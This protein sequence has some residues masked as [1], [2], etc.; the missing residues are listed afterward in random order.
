MMEVLQTG[1]VVAGLVLLVW[2]WARRWGEGLLVAMVLSW[3]SLFSWVVFAT[4]FSWPISREY[5]AGGQ[6]LVGIK[7]LIIAHR[8]GVKIWRIEW[9]FNLGWG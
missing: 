8:S 6:V 9:D 4:V 2:G 5:L 1:L 3:H 7:G